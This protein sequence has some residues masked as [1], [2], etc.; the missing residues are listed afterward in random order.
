MTRLARTIIISL[1]KR[2]FSALTSI[3]GFKYDNQES[4]MKEWKRMVFF[5]IKKNGFALL[6]PTYQTPD[7]SIQLAEL[8][9]N[10]QLNHYTNENGFSLICGESK[11]TKDLNSTLHFLPHTD[12]HYLNSVFQSNDKF[13]SL[14]PPRLILLQCLISNNSGGESLLYDAQKSLVSFLKEDIN[15]AVILFNTFMTIMRHD[16]LCANVPILKQFDKNRFSIRYS[17][18]NNLIINLEIDQLLKEFNSHIEKSLILNQKLLPN[19]ILLIDNTRMLHGRKNFTGE[20]VFKRIWVAEGAKELSRAKIKEKMYVSSKSS[21][22]SPIEPYNK[23]RLLK[24]DTRFPRSVETGIVLPKKYYSRL[25]QPANNLK[26]PEICD[27]KMPTQ[28]DNQN[29]K[30]RPFSI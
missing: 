2:F 12:G 4:L 20:R 18:D 21:G 3:K 10:I 8:I 29:D 28:L 5:P 11:N 25:F 9:G 15:K 30:N 14:D 24:L 1:P 13:F 6:E 19:Q 7:P 26:K 17:Y 23:Y 27:E 16:I 22:K